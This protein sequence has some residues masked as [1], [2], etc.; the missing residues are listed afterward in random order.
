[1]INELRTELEHKTWRARK[2]RQIIVETAGHRFNV[3][4]HKTNDTV[5]ITKISIIRGKR[6][7][8]PKPRSRMKRYQKE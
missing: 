6:G 3:G 7:I 2:K 1:M 8:A 4:C 5:R